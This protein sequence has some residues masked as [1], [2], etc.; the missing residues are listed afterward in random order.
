[1]DI[2]AA[3]LKEHSKQQTMKIVRYIG[4]DPERFQAL[5][6]LF[7]GKEYRVTQRSAWVLSYVIS[8]HP[9]LIAPYLA[10]TIDL[11]SNP[12]APPAVARNILRF[13]EHI[14]V[15]E[16]L[17]GRLMDAC[18]RYLADSGTPIAIK[19]FA[20]TV[21]HN[22]SKLYPG[23]LPE[24][25]AIIRDRWRYETPA[26]HARARRMLKDRIPPVGRGAPTHD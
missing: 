17:Q 25:E 16:E 20:L 9:T 7:L 21:L 18:F 22:L 6:V 2:R 10:Q 15:P 11:V 12:G 14:D 13:M 3:L 4:D 26:F 24:L 23:I 5:M 19:V 1:M 8:Q